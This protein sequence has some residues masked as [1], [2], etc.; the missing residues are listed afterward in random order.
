MRNSK[1]GRFVKLTAAFIGAATIALAVGRPSYAIDYKGLTI[2]PASAEIKLAPG[3]VYHGEFEVSNTTDRT[4]TARIDAGTYNI[5]NSNYGAPDYD[6]SG[7]YSEMARWMTIANPNLS[8]QPGAKQKVKYTI[9][10]PNNPPAGTQYASLLTVYK[11][12]EEGDQKAGAQLSFT[13]RISY[14]I[15][16]QM[17]GGQTNDRANISS[18]DIAGYQPMS[19]LKAKF[20]VKNEGNVS[21]TTKYTLTVKNAIN[22][23]EV[24]KSEV[25]KDSVYPETTRNFEIQWKGMGVGFYN[26][27]LNVSLNGRDHKFNQFVVAVPI[28]IFILIFVGILCLVGYAILNY[29]MVKKAKSHRK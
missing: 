21:T 2:S 26:V 24:Y 9:T 4:R 17:Q 22:G 7:K 20:A 16:A 18:H 28:W 8:L 29:R 10:V 3:Q 5:V 11:D 19:P 13:S 25:N 12:A 14:V 6:N 27:E 23:T 1:W 15:T